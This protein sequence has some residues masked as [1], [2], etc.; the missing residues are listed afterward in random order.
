MFSS[1][2]FS[3]I[4]HV[5]PAHRFIRPHEPVVRAAVIHLKLQHRAH[6]HRHQQRP[7]DIKHQSRFRIAHLR[8]RTQRI[9][10]PPSRRAA[11]FVLIARPALRARANF[12]TFPGTHDA[13][14]PLR[15][16]AMSLKRII[17]TA[18]ELPCRATP[19]HRARSPARA[20]ETRTRA[21]THTT[22]AAPRVAT[23][24]YD[25][26]ATTTTRGASRARV[27]SFGRSVG[28]HRGARTHAR[29]THIARVI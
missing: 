10:P 25:D 6:R 15:T 16:A 3:R 8:I 24:L 7:N 13:I 17:H 4:Q 19:R 26:D 11:A 5:R 27:L 20:S 9:P 12:R 1:L 21:P 29:A 22:P 18:H 14:H 23:T 2:G 28:G